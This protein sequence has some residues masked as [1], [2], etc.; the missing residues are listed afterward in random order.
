M[1]DSL[2]SRSSKNGSCSVE[3][4]IHVPSQEKTPLHTVMVC[5]ETIWLPQWVSVR[6]R[7]LQRHSECLCTQPHRLSQSRSSGGV[8]GQN[9]QETFSTLSKSDHYGSS[10]ELHSQSPQ[11]LEYQFKGTTN[12]AKIPFQPQEEELKC[13]CVHQQQ[14]DFI[15]NLWTLS[16][17][18]RGCSHCLENQCLFNGSSKYLIIISQSRIIRH[19]SNHC[20]A[21]GYQTFSLRSW[22]WSCLSR[23]SLW[24][25]WTHQQERPWLQG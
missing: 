9:H 14:E 21:I 16:A 23:S 19:D 2:D 20:R 13:E 4:Q 8:L 3:N 6:S 11:S 15:V 24:S 1:A 7:V 17:T 5:V 12:G 25:R 10:S 22:T 18:Q